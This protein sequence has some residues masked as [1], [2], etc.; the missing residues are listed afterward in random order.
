MEK[1]T[2]EEIMYGDKHDM[3]S[4]VIV[5]IFKMVQQGMLA[6]EIKKT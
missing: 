6:K 5:E 2:L 1:Y 4:A 3:E